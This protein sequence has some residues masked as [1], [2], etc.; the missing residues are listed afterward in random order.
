VA[1]TADEEGGPANG[2]DWLVTQHRDLID[3]EYCI[4]TDG[5]G[6]LLKNGKP[7]FLG[8]DAA[9]K[10]YLSFKLEVTDSGGHSSLPTK[11]NPSSASPTPYPG[12]ASSTSPSICSTSA[13]PISRAVPAWRAGRTER[14]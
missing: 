11:D 1:L 4:N 7:V 9:E 13:G 3:A 14:T 10:I 6:G 2:I 12:S 5:G 8:L